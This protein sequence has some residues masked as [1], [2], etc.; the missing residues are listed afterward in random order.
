MPEPPPEERLHEDG[1]IGHLVDLR[2]C[3]V[4]SLLAV[5]VLFMAMFPFYEPIYAA[6]SQPILAALPPEG[7]AQL[8]ATDV[9]GGF[10]VPAKV[11]LF[12]AL[13]VALP[14]VLYQVWAFVAP[15]L[16]LRE[17]RMVLP[18]V[19]SSTALFYLGMA[20]A[21]LLVFKVVFAFIFKFAPAAFIVMPDVQSHLSF[22]L[23]M[24]FVFGLAFEVPV[25]VFLLVQMGVI[26]LA[27]LRHAR[28]YVIVGAFI[29]A[30]IIT[31]PDVLSQFMLALPVWL[32][33][34]IGILVA[35]LARRRKGTQEAADQA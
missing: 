34:E 7:D 20:F 31:P 21:Y 12:C 35:S 14:Y 30:A 19:V 10:L 1:I 22:A 5:G 16:Y 4:R 15:G 13:C 33:Y 28:P 29:C 32:L 17:R 11:V 26:S 6:F 23:T 25:A 9:L 3:A 2:K 27:A 18:L 24:F 8:I